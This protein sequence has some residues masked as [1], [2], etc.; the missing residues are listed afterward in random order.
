MQM[1][2]LSHEII[3]VL[4]GNGKKNHKEPHSRYISNLTTAMEDCN[5]WKKFVDCLI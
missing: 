2:M 1:Q 4:G 3:F 5:T